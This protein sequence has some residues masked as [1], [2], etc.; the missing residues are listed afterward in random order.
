MTVPNGVV[1]PRIVGIAV[2]R[3]VG[4]EYLVKYWRNAQVQANLQLFQGNG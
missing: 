3:T 1:A 4:V 2:S